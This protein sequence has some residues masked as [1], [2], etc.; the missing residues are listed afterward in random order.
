MHKYD[1]FY[2]MCLV[3]ILN[4]YLSKCNAKIKSKSIESFNKSTTHELDLTFE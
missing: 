2:N 1:T 4:V 3:L